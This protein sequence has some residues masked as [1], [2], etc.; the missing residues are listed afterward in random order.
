[1]GDYLNVGNA[2]FTSVRKGLYVDKT[3]MIAFING[4]LG[5]TDKLTCVSRPRRFG[6]SFAAKMLCAYYDKSC[7]SQK[8]F[9][10]LR[11]A[12]DESFRKHLNKYDVIYLDITWFI[13]IVDDM[14]RV[15]SYLQKAVIQELREAYPHVAVKDTLA[16]T[17][18]RITDVTGNKF[19][20]IIDEWDALFR[21]A[22]YDQDLQEEYIQ[23]LRGLFKSSGQTD[24]MIEAAYLTGILPIKKYGTQSAVSDF[25]EY[26]M[27]SPGKLAKYVGFTE[28]EV[29]ML[30]ERH[31]M[32]F[33]EMKHW[34]DGYSISCLKS[35]YNPNSVMEAIKNE[36]FGN[37]WTRTETYESLKIY[38]ELNEDGLREAIVQMLGGAHFKINVGSFQNDMTTIKVKDDVLTL[39]VHLGY[40]E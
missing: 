26:T 15:V 16:E 10:N 36:E 39:L 5:T 31:G 23:M 8:L 4:T 20:I 7:D 6:K 19:I 30:C 1:M 35:V 22:K 18:S 27:I 28:D 37:F 13:S 2:G 12:G 40:N 11:I 32:D 17:L 21:E 9:E 34:Y 24:K 29:N 14:K 33:E 38:I 25:R 3:D